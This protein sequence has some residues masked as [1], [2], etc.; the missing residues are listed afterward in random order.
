MA[1]NEIAVNSIMVSD[2]AGKV[3]SETDKLQSVLDSIN[4]TCQQID[5][6]SVWTSDVQGVCMSK[7]KEILNQFPDIIESM[8]VYSNF[9]TS[10]YSAYVSAERSYTTAT[11]KL[12]D[13][14]GIGGTL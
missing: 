1:G 3:A 4:A 13:G 5:M 11:D 8:K 10:V 9:L 7:Y 12:N 6:T 2:F 14:T